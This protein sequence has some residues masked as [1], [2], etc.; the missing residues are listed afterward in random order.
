MKGSF[1]GQHGFGS[2][3]FLLQAVLLCIM[4][5]ATPALSKTINVTQPP[6]SATGNGTADDSAAVQAAIAA[7]KPGDTVL[8]PGGTYLLSTLNAAF[9]SGIT[10]Q[11]KSNPV[12]NVTG[13]LNYFYISD[14]GKCDG[15][16][17]Q[18]NINPVVCYG[19]NWQITNCSFSGTGAGF[20]GC[21]CEGQ[22]TGT[23][24]G[25]TFTVDS[26]QDGFVVDGLSKVVIQN[27]TF[28][29]VAESSGGIGIYIDG[30]PQTANVLSN[31][32]TSLDYGIKGQIG[33]YGQSG[34]TSLKAQNNIFTGCTYATYCSNCDNVTFDSNTISQCTNGY[35]G[36]GNGPDA[37]TN[38]AMDLTPNPILLQDDVSTCNV[39]GNTL[40]RVAA[41]TN[42]TGFGAAAIA[43]DGNSIS[44]T[45]VRNNLTSGGNAYNGILT[46]NCFNVKDSQ[47]TVDG[48]AEPV[49]SLQ[50]DNVTIQTNSVNNSGS[51]G[52]V[53]GYDQGT[54]L[55]SGNLLNNI[56]GAPESAAI[57]L[58][59]TEDATIK[60]NT[61]NQSGPTLLTYFIADASATATLI[62]NKTNTMLP[63]IP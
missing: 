58:L 40:T 21:G 55:I 8:F 50:D 30:S 6:Y 23:I 7:A 11:G 61:Y 19:A 52:I 10:L 4:L 60:N 63:S 59:Y 33:Q 16:S 48:F 24:S 9:V 1:V 47:N 28:T 15:I 51:V 26:D 53:I 32:F 31:T 2:A 36:T 5:T 27:N 12:L 13:F 29:A 46:A 14:K 3:L 54:I 45:V 34:P 35:S 37:V 18:G 39:T 56:A 42:Y 17:F 38:N 20:I 62:N 22:S 41:G 25:C 43:I 57:A 44:T 49:A